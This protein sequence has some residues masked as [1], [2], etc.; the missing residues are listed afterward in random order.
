MPPDEEDQAPDADTFRKVMLAL[1]LLIGVTFV[2]WQV[3]EFKK[4]DPLAF[5]ARVKRRLELRRAERLRRKRERYEVAE[6]GLDLYLYLE[7][8]VEK[9]RAKI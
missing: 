2:L 5:P 9:W 8:E 1:D 6:L 7:R 4:D 3:W